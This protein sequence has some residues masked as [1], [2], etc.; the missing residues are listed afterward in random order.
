VA[1]NLSGGQDS[2]MKH[3]PKKMQQLSDDQFSS[4]KSIFTIFV[5][6]AFLGIELFEFSCHDCRLERKGFIGAESYFLTDIIHNVS[7]T[8]DDKMTK[9]TSHDKDSPSS[10][11]DNQEED[12][13]FTGSLLCIDRHS[14]SIFLYDW[15]R[16][17][18]N[19]N[20]KQG[21]RGAKGA[22]IITLPHCKYLLTNAVRESYVTLESLTYSEYS[23]R[24][25]NGSVEVHELLP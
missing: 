20:E 16:Q 2:T 7:K 11:M 15:R 9:E 1:P 12:S 14:G 13:K 4:S 23:V 6:I 10:E 18:L 8:L 3:D 19:Q 17:W 22:P 5:A 25:S 24:D 21:L